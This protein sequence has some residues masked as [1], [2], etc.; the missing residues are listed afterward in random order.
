[1]GDCIE[2]ACKW[3]V[4]LIGNNPQN[5]HPIDEYNCAIAWIPIL[6]VETTKTGRDTHNRVEQFRELVTQVV[7][8]QAVKAPTPELKR[9]VGI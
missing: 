8:S 2:H 3:Y 9:M 4:H 7:K 1:M 5:D 6:L